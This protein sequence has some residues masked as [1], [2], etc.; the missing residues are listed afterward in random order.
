[1]TKDKPKTQKYSKTAFLDAAIDSNERLLL[2]TLLQDGTSYTKDD[3]A[4]VVEAWKS[5]PI[6]E[7]KKE[8][9]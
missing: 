4:K 5:K 3:V 7:K 9:K 6:K 8:V 2:D 1:M